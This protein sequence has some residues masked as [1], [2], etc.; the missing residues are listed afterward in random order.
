[1][2]QVFQEKVAET[3]GVFW[4]SARAVKRAVPVEFQDDHKV[5]HGAV[6]PLKTACG[7]QDE[8]RQ[9]T[10]GRQIWRRSEARVA[11]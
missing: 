5:N 10:A 7:S 1:M 4:G 8:R 3:N 2:R 11:F 6:T 9:E